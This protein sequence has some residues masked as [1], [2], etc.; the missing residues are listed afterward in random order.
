[1]SVA[2]IA[3]LQPPP[4]LPP[5]L[6]ADTRRPAESLADQLYP[7]RPRHFPSAWH[8]IVQGIGRQWP[9]AAVALIVAWS[10]IWVLLAIAAIFIGVAAV[11]AVVAAFMTGGAGGLVGIAVSIWAT[12]LA[13]WSVALA[14]VSGGPALLVDVAGG[15]A[16]SLLVFAGMVVAEPLT[17]QLRGYRRMSRREAD[18]IFPL[19]YEAARRMGMRGAPQVVMSDHARRTANTYVRHIVLSRSLYDDHTDEELAAVLAHE[20]HH[21][22]RAD[23]VGLHFVFASALPL[24]LI[25]NLASKLV[26]FRSFVAVLAWLV[27]WPAQAFMWLLIKPLMAERGRRHEYEA[28]AAAKAAG[29]GAGLIRC[30]SIDREF[31]AARSGW[32]DVILA[33][34][35]PTE[36]RLEALDT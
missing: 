1:M 3:N 26:R 9:A 18:R 28:D 22:A 23:A 4:P 10:G 17:L 8:W 21:W 24:V 16:T 14:L 32:E 35:P 6:V 15:A 11:F 13:A 19:L 7:G 31:E 20:L 30:I 5:P 25:F 27:A 34:H 36:L 33:T 29:Y 2:E 12:V